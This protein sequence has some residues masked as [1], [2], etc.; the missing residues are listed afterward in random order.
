MR[1]CIRHMCSLFEDGCRRLLC[2][3][4]RILLR[5]PFANTIYQVKPSSVVIIVT[6]DV[7]KVDLNSR[8]WRA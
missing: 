3:K 7:A 1:D 4:L 5:V 2:Q 8:R 6:D